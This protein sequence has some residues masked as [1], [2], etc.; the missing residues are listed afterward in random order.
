[1]RRANF[2]GGSEHNV[3]PYGQVV[4]DNIIHPL[5]DQLAASSDYETGAAPPSPPSM[6]AARC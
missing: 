6:P 3:T 1:V 5:T 4:D 2:Y